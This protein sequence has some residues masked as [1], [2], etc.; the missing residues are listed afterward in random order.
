MTYRGPATITWP[1]GTTLDVDLRVDVLHDESHGYP[2][3]NFEI[4]AI[5]PTYPAT[6]RVVDTLVTI[7]FAGA[8]ARAKTE[9]LNAA[10]HE[11]TSLDLIAVEDWSQALA[12]AQKG[13]NP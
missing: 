3:W 12:T 13:S 5:S 2:V 7:K 6:A 4:T 10:L 1:D 11:D 8:T 9:L